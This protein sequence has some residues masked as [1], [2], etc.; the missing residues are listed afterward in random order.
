MRVNEPPLNEAAFFFCPRLANVKRYVDEHDS[1]PL[2]LGQAAHIAGMERTYFSKYFHER[3]GVCFKDWIAFERI[4]RAVLMLT[5]HDHNITDL[6]FAVGFQDLRTFERAFKKFVGI[7]PR[8]CRGIV[9]H[10][11]AD[12]PEERSLTWAEIAPTEH[13]VKL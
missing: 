7:T 6:A 1:E 3:T 4:K 10:H 2:T 11:M 9:R 8:E 5:N 12:E 13:D